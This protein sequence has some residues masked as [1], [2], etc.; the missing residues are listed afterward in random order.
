M[1]PTVTTVVPGAST[2]P[3]IRRLHQHHAIHRRDRHGIGELRIDQRQAGLRPRDFRAPR[4][5]LLFAPLQFQRVRLRHLHA[6]R[7]PA[8]PAPPARSTC[9]TRGPATTSASRSLRL[10]QRRLRRSR[11]GCGTDRTARSKCRR[12]CTASARAPSPSAR[13]PPRSAAASTAALASCFSC[14]RAPFCSSARRASAAATSAR[15]VLQVRRQ[16][17][18]LEF[19][20]GLRL[21]QLRFAGRQ[22]RRPRARAA[23][24]V[25]RDPDA[26][27]PAPSSPRR[28]RPPCARPAAR[29]S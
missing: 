24:A 7:A 4:G 5:E 28:P 6:R 16:A 10:L 15:R 3:G 17:R 22:A 29:R 8:P 19:E 18:P 23:P 26:R 9:S 1:S 14:G 11:S 13:A 25:D 21:R 27:S 20:R 2:S 12:S